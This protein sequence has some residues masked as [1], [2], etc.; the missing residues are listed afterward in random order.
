[1]FLS[2]L[3][4]GILRARGSIDHYGEDWPEWVS[5][6]PIDVP[7]RSKYDLCM[8]RSGVVGPFQ[9]NFSGAVL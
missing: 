8:V 3:P 1:M 7:I 9:I 6:L 2:V 5:V 4:V